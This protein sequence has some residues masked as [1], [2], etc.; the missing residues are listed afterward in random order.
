[1]APRLIATGIPELVPM[2]R[3]GDPR[4]HVSYII[5]KLCIALGHF[6][7]NGG[8]PSISLMELGSA[9]EDA[10]A[11]SLAAR[12]V[13]SQPDRF[14]QPG[15]IEVDGLIGN[16]DLYD[17]VDNAV[18]EVKLTK[19][20]ARNDIESIKFWKYWVQLKA[21][22]WMVGTDLGRLHIGHINGDYSR[23]AGPDIIYNVWEE[24]FTKQDLYEN[25][26]ML[27]SHCDAD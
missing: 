16:M 5:R 12:Y 8:P 27:K 23:T 18:I 3:T 4:R 19:I 25:W 21:Y 14:V 7:D 11:T 6:E 24:R 22:C 17:T 9:F 15:P 10:V 26:R 13:K 1:M 2:V 20:S